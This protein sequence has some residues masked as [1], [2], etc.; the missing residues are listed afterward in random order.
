MPLQLET[1][2]DVSL[3]LLCIR[4]RA[5][6]FVK[7]N[8]AWHALLGYRP[9]DLEG[10]AML[11]LVHPDDVAATRAQMDQV[12]DEPA[13]IADNFINRYRHRYGHYLHLEW[14]AREIN[15][16]VY[17]VARDVSGRVAAEGLQHALTQELEAK[18]AQ[19]VKVQAV[20]KIGT[21]ETDVK[22]LQVKW[23]EETFRIF[24]KD[25]ATFRPRH[26]DFLQ[27]VH[28]EDR[29]AVDAAFLHSVGSLDVFSIH[30][31]LLLPDGRV[32]HVEERWQAIADPGGEISRVIGTCQDITERH[33]AQLQGEA[34]IS[35][36]LATTQAIL[37][38]SPDIIC[39]IGRDGR[40]VQINRRAEEIWG[41]SPAELAGVEFLTLVHPE[42]H[43]AAL[44]HGA[45][46]MRGGVSEGPMN[47]CL[48]KQGAPI[49]MMWSA[50]W[51][52]RHQMVFAVARD[53][54]PQLAAE[55]RLRQAQ[56]M[57][58]VGRLTGGVAHDF[59]NL[60]TVIIGSTE[61]LADG[62]GERPD[63]RSY[64]KLAL[65]AAERGAELVARLLA[66]SRNQ[67]LLPQVLDCNEVLESVRQMVG[68]TFTENIEV[69][70][71]EGPEGLRCMADRTHLTTALLNL[72]INARDAMPAG[73]KVTL[74]ASRDSGADA[75]R[76]RTGARPNGLVRFSVEDNGHGMTADTR[77]RATEPFFTTKFVGDGSGL[78]LS[79]VYGFTKQS[80]GRL[81][82]ESEPG[83]GTRIDLHLPESQDLPTK[84]LPAGEVTAG[85]VTGRVLVVEDD[86]LLRSQVERQLRALGH[87][88]TVA[89]NGAEALQLISADQTFDI[90]MTDVVMPEGI[91]G[92]E[93]AQRGRAIA[94]AMRSL[95]T[96]G[97]NED[98]FLRGNGGH[99]GDDFLP[100]PYRRADLERKV[101][102]L[103][104]R[105]PAP[106]DP[107]RKGK[108][109]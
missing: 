25:A 54:R 107:G 101:S 77:E 23:S 29:G 91:N 35:A 40:I 37:D 56:K 2:F 105:L 52:E 102:G 82:I 33:E 50:M 75:A 17:G 70:V 67:P 42:D 64:T 41:Y 15:R 68:Q 87:T 38:N 43:A 36:A 100:K 69:A 85:L 16:M 76:Q 32:K 44:A 26:E 106:G 84:I 6:H 73:G 34:E 81:E 109:Q 31:R 18:H 55:D 9:E 8:A 96:S 51:S 45:Q 60:L 83:S 108:D 90:L 66:F 46:L 57:E 19:L 98:V 92:R 49:P 89:S 53:M 1:F 74:R 5:G 94:P 71:E 97:H 39:T 86:D 47:R 65:E 21:W 10:V 88:V 14:R 20:A 104:T 78:G 12:D 24:A 62:L 4:D 93:L 58:A 30:H 11:S 3:D 80:G 27:L 79:M 95:L 22:T 72:C 7:V 103:L 99:G 13:A 28:P 59:N 48:A 63:L 61:A